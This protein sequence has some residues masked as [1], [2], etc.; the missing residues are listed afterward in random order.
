MC[1]SAKPAGPRTFGEYNNYNATI[2][3]DL[4]HN[5][6]LDINEPYVNSLNNN[7]FEFPNLDDG[8]YLVRT[9]IPDNCYQLYPGL[10]GSVDYNHYNNYNKKIDNFVDAIIE[11]YHE[12]YSLT[13][14]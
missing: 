9:I 13:I 11:Y 3:I 4:N 8:N 10:N 12:G 5:G 2:Y 7:K 14:P 6:I 1:R